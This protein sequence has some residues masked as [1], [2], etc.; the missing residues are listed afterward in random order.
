MHK[1]KEDGGGG[2]T[3]FPSALELLSGIIGKPAH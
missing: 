1:G 2:E 3:T